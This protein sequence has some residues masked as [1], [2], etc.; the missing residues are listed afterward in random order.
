MQAEQ[1]VRPAWDIIREITVAGH[2]G[3]SVFSQQMV[4]KAKVLFGKNSSPNVVQ[5]FCW[6]I[7]ALVQAV[8]VNSGEYPGGGAAGSSKTRR[9]VQDQELK[10]CVMLTT[11]SNAHVDRFTTEACRIWDCGLFSLYFFSLRA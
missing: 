10:E 1:W 4:D 6:R 7:R 9:F 5:A 2:T 8:D 3:A 11:A